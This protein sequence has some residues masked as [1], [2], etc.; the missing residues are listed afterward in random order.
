MNEYAR[1]YCNGRPPEPALEVDVAIAYPAACEQ[2]CS[3]HSTPAGRAQEAFLRRDGK[4]AP[5]RGYPVV[6]FVV[7]T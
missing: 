7:L 1:S 5:R 2:L 4:V 6:Q 3:Y